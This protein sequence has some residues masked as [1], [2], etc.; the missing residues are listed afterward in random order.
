[1]YCMNCGNELKTGAKACEVCGAAVPTGAVIPVEATVP[2]EASVGNPTRPPHN[3]FEY[4]RTVVDSDLVTVAS[5]C[6]E[7]LGW[8]ITGVAKNGTNHSSTLSFRRNRKVKGKAQLVKLQH[9]MDDLLSTLANLEQEKTR[10]ASIQ[11]LGLGIL[12]ALILG[13]GMCC[14]M[15]WADTLM[16]PGIVVGVIGLIACAANYFLF[17]K[18]V[19]KET[20][21]VTPR[22]E[23]AYDS[24]ATLCEEA[25]TVQ[26]A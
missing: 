24:L 20:E 5:D 7:N 9:K 15:V 8:E 10:R 19:A 6:Y 18:T 22:I 1:M 23:A 16:A 2:M 3:S 12:A 13:V 4:T 11:A 14:T 17:R 21:R 26:A 25:Q